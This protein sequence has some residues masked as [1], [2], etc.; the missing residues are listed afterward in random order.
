[1]DKVFNRFFIQFPRNTVFGWGAQIEKIDIMKIMA[2]SYHKRRFCAC[3]NEFPYVLKLKYLDFQ[4]G[5]AQ[6]YSINGN[7]SM[8][9]TPFS[10]PEVTNLTV[11]DGYL[12]NYVVVSRRFK[13]EDECIKFN[14]NIKLHVDIIGDRIDSSLLHYSL[15]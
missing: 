1:M 5:N 6:Y 8:F 11:D 14:K 15:N 3:D 10:N 12:K 9:N 7:P 13:T 2:T 4:F